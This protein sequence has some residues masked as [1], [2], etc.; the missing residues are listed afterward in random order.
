MT[1]HTSIN[2]NNNTKICSF[3]VQQLHLINYKLN[4]NNI[5]NNIYKAT[6]HNSINKLN[7]TLTIVISVHEQKKILFYFSD[8]FQSYVNLNDSLSL[9]SCHYYSSPSFIKF[10]L[11][12]YSSV[13][14]WSALYSLIDSVDACVRSSVYQTLPPS[15]PEPSVCTSQPASQNLELL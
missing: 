3:I 4:Y 11:F 6:R 12:V 7:R 1:I 10:P 5:Y 8:V 15:P 13:D 2:N 14:D 9:F